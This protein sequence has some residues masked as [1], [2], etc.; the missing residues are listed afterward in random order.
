MKP[1][2]ARFLRH[3]YDAVMFTGVGLV[4]VFAVELSSLFL[5]RLRLV[6]GRRPRVLL[7][8]R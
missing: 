3:P 1:L 4:P 6:T 7:P 8:S 2:L 5:L